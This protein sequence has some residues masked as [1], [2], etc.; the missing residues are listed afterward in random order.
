MIIRNK[1]ENRKEKNRK[2]RTEK[3]YLLSIVNKSHFVFFSG[4]LF[5][6]FGNP[7]PP[8][9]VLI[10]A[11]LFCVYDNPSRLVSYFRLCDTAILCVCFFLI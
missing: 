6:F 2:K 10:Q 1:K 5:C 7:T 4:P 3:E 8:F 9:F 11:P